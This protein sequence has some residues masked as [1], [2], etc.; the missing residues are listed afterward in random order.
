ML[1]F[2]P[3]WQLSTTKPLTHCPCVWMGETIRRVKVRKLVGWDKDN[4]ID[5][6]KASGTSKA[7]PG[8]HS[9]LPMGGQAGVQPSPGK[10]GSITRNGDLGRQTPSLWMSLPSSFFPQLY[11]LSMTSYGMEYP[12][13]QFGSAVLCVSP[14]NFLGTPS[15]LAGGVVWEAEKALALWKHH[16]AVT[17]MVCYQQC[18][19]N[20]SKT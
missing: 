17:K 1:W 2:N 8:I 16:W 18:F 4:L 12:F 10:Q 7:K 13:G 9:P 5:K 15:P 6:A 3:R 19:Q 20:K 11:M 14:P